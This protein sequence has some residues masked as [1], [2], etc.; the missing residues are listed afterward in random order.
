MTDQSPTGP[1]TGPPPGPPTGP[2]TGP[3]SAE[4][5]KPF[6]KTPGLGSVLVA[7]A[8]VA[9]A[10][11]GGMALLGD[12]DKDAAPQPAGEILLEPVSFQTPDPFTESV[13]ERNPTPFSTAA[14]TTS[15]QPAPEADDSASTTAVPVRSVEGSTPGLYGGTRDNATCDAQ[16]LITFLQAN[17]DKAAAWAGVLGVTVAAIPDYVR[18]LTPVVLQSDTR[19]TNHGYRDGRATTLNSVLQAGTAVLVDDRGVP[20][21]KCA[22]GNPLTEPAPVSG[23][24]TYTGQSWPSFDPADV[25]AVAPAP[26]PMTVIILVA[27]NGEPFDRTVGTFGD[28]DTLLAADALCDL[29]PDDEQCGAPTDGADG[30][31][32]P[33]LGTGD[34]QITLRWSSTAD[35]DLAVTDPEG[36][37]IYYDSPTAPSGGQLDV[38]SNGG[39]DAT[40]S[41]PVENIYWPETSAPDGDYLITVDYFETCP[42]G[43]GPQAFTLTFL[44]GGT[45]STVIP[46]SFAGDISVQLLVA[47]G[48]VSVVPA[49]Q[50]IG[51]A[52]GGVLEP[53]GSMNFTG[54]KGP[55]HEPTPVEP[56]PDVPSPVVPTPDEPTPDVPTPVEPPADEPT[57]PTPE[58]PAETRPA[59]V[60][61][62]VQPGIAQL[63]EWIKWC[64]IP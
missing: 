61:C 56:T 12:D 27:E 14:P 53:G 24:A 22:C 38:D 7:V 2:P 3:P 17:G 57:P 35:L 34:V 31:V 49:F 23:P 30:T 20:R 28:S 8:L 54:S 5:K 26:A 62:D 37:R 36:A 18:S 9:A 43:E 50:D 63:Q 15:T 33:E 60:D 42:G 41:T 13:D 11:G 64:G 44:V 10:V 55:G 6:W 21:V 48:E 46:A 45:P 51:T 39:C 47:R 16:Q 59:W 40:T 19:V 32:E 1:P 52:F 4:A 58:P 29:F 25:V